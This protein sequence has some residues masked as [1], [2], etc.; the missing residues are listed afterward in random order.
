MLFNSVAPIIAAIWLAINKEWWP[1]LYAMGFFVC[2]SLLI[3]LLLKPADLIFGLPAIH[4]ELSG[5][6]IAAFAF[7]L[8][9]NAF[10]FVFNSIWC[11]AV[12][13]FFTLDAKPKSLIPLLMLS[14]W[15][16]TEPWLYLTMKKV[17]ENE[18]S[19]SLTILSIISQIAYVV[20]TILL[21]VYPKTYIIGYCAFF[22]IMILGFFLLEIV[23]VNELKNK[24]SFSD[25]ESGP[26]DFNT[27]L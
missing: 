13:L 5:R 3:G 4:F 19:I 20:M 17:K 16:A 24:R 12:L 25:Y 8:F 1:I 15:V 21:V 6:K 7:N 9:H 22:L 2:A 26:Q 18:E 27:D 14:F 23:V 11:F 10:C